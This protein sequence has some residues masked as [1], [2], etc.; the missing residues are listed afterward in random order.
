MCVP[1]SCVTVYFLVLVTK[2]PSKLTK[3]GNSIPPHLRP[4]SPN[5]P[6]TCPE[7]GTAGQAITSDDVCALKIELLLA[8]RKDFREFKGVSLD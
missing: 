7:L 5:E 4:A 8:L 6:L 3:G 2:M 1:R